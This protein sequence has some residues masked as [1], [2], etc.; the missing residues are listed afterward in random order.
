MKKPELL[1]L[2]G[3]T[4]AHW[5]YSCSPELLVISSP[6]S[7]ALLTVEDSLPK[8]LYNGASG[9]VYVAG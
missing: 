5:S 7:L 3:A 8:L 6:I 9:A 2:I 1:V 4:R